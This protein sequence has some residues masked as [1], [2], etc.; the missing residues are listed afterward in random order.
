MP[1]LP[2]EY[3]DVN[4]TGNTKQLY[5]TS[6]S[7]KG[8]KNKIAPVSG[9]FGTQ[10]IQDSRFKQDGSER[11]ALLGKME[12]ARMNG[13]YSSCKAPFSIYYNSHM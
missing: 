6:L 10:V 11:R 7:N 5:Y 1:C 9:K 12:T 3:G 2:P 13:S 4:L 8:E